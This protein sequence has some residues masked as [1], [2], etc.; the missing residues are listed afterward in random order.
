MPRRRPKFG[1]LALRLALV[2][3]PYRTDILGDLDDEERRLEKAAGATI[4]ARR[5]GRQVWRSAAALLIRPPLTNRARIRLLAVSVAVYGV[6]VRLPDLALMGVA[7]VWPAASGTA[8]RIVLLAAVL[9]AASLAGA[10]LVGLE[11]KAPA[12]AMLFFTLLAC[13]LGA[14]HVGEAPSFE[15][16]FRLLKVAGFLLMAAAGGLTACARLARGRG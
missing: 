5:H 13:L 7:Q 14:R 1:V 6:A 3:H 12:T 8:V 9:I 4:A 2:G 16:S 15:M 11:R 10:L